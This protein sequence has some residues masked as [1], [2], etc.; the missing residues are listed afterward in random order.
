MKKLNED[1]MASLD[2]TS[3]IGAPELASRGVEGSG[4]IVPVQK[5]KKV[6]DFASF[7]A[8]GN[9]IDESKE[10][11]NSGFQFEDSLED[12]LRIDLNNFLEHDSIDKTV[13]SIKYSVQVITAKF[14]I[15]DL[16]P[17]V[18]ELK[19]VVKYTDMNEEAKEESFIIE[20]KNIVI[21]KRKILLPFSLDEAEIDFKTKKAILY[22]GK[23]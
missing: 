23:D 6:F 2:S 7:I 5:K 11:I 17:T 15:E 20:S 9:V 16:E 8:A 18:Q 4:D 3:G 13:V 12:H 19:V 14:G 21:E 1:A 10:Y 22:F